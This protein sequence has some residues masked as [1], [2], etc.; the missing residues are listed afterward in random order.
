MFSSRPGKSNA[1]VILTAG[2]IIPDG[3][4][5][6]LVKS[7]KN[8]SFLVLTVPP[9][10]RRTRSRP[11]CRRNLLPSF[12][13]DVGVLLIGSNDLGCFSRYTKN[14]NVHYFD[15]APDHELFFA[16]MT[17]PC[18]VSR[19]R[20]IKNRLR[21]SP[22][23]V[24]KVGA[25]T[26]LTM[27]RFERIQDEP[28][29]GWYK[30]KD[31]QWDLEKEEKD[32]NEWI[33]VVHWMDVPF[34]ASG[35]SGSLVFAREDGIYIP[36]GIHLGGREARRQSYFSSLET[37]CYE[38]ETEGLQLHFHYSMTSGGDLANARSEPSPSTTTTS[39]DDL[40]NAR[41]EP[42]SP[43]TTTSIND[44]ANSESESSS[45]TTTMSSDDVAN[46]KSEPS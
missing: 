10:F 9:A 15:P 3:D 12:Q 33:G 13:D 17:D 26:D 39:G 37:F 27:G 42:S 46:A 29:H 11:R 31:D 16:Q 1:E 43:T 22:I 18:S 14:L 2:H 35:D 25:A 34:S 24:Y 28:P 20:A 30:P 23:I 45:P 44:L 5:E 40:A 6:V 21:I 41:S 4:D 32:E 38:A 7:R 8:D 19:R 36:L